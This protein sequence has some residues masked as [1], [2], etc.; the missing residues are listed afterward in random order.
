MI[1]SYPFI[2]MSVY[3]YILK[4]KNDIRKYI[5]KEHIYMYI[6]NMYKI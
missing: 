6:T 3:I 5:Y 1:P 2:S 4:H